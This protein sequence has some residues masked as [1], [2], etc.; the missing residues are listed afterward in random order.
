MKELNVNSSIELKPTLRRVIKIWWAYVWRYLV[1]FAVSLIIAA[2]AGA[3]LGYSM[4]ARGYS[5]ESM[6]IA[7]YAVGL[8]I[9][10]ATTI[11]P[12]KLIIGKQF[13]G[14]R[15]VLLKASATSKTGPTDDM[16]EAMQTIERLTK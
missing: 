15:V 7:G 12:L 4:G 1:A 6:E 11:V 14:F 3:V 9:A 10:V 16:H 5:R 2:V 8:F 13:K